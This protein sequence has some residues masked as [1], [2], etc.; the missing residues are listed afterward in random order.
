MIYNYLLPQDP[1]WDEWGERYQTGLST[2]FLSTCRE[3]HDEATSLLYGCGCREHEISLWDP[4][5]VSFLN[6]FHEIDDMS[7]EDLSQLNSVAYR[8]AL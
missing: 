8:P 4:G 2:A 3:I 5:A 6:N 7:P 1:L